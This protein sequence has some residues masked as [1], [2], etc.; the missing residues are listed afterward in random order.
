M[1]SIKTCLE[2]IFNYGMEL[3]TH[4]EIRLNGG[5]YL[6]EVHGGGWED[7]WQ[8]QIE[9][10]PKTPIFFFTQWKIFSPFLHKKNKSVEYI[11]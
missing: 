2:L 9:N 1:K 3:L 7:L 10:A 6:S 8:G 4:I 5:F 11:E